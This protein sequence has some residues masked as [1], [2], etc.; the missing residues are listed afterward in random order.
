MRLRAGRRTVRQRGGCW[1]LRWCSTGRIARRRPRPA[2]WIA[3]PCGTGC[4]ATT[5]RAWAGCMIASRRVPSRNSRPNSWPGWSRRAPIRRVTGWCAGGAWICAT[6]CNG[7]SAS[8]CTN[9][10]SA[11]CWRSSATAGSLCARAIRRRMKKPRRH[12]KKLR[13]DARC[14]AARPCQ[15][16]AR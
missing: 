12:L 4:I 3:R 7:A 15:R 1:R 5:L 11:R 16:Q 10:R 6:S 9:A 14:A 13:R 8:R 2:A